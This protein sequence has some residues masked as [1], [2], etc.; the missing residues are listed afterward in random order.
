MAGQSRCCRNT[1]EGNLNQSWSQ[2]VAWS[3]GQSSIS[4]INRPWCQVSRKIDAFQILSIG[5]FLLIQYLRHVFE[6]WFGKTANVPWQLS[7]IHY[8]YIC[9]F[10]QRNQ[11]GLMGSRTWERMK[12]VWVWFHAS[13]GEG[14]YSLF[15]QGTWDVSC[16]STMLQPKARELGFHFPT[17]TSLSPFN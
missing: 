16:A 4:L 8:I 14:S 7:H 2:E 10:S 1:W 11:W 3:R 13:H 17:S 6:T 12:P 5:F 15:S 9:I